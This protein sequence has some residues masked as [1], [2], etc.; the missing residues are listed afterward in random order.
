MPRPPTIRL[1]PLQRRT[2]YGV[3]TLLWLSGALWLAFHYFLR[4]PS[5]FGDKPHALEIWWLRLHGLAGFAA[6]VAV[7]SMLPVHV[8]RAWALD[9]NR[10]SGVVMKM[11]FFW[12]AT[13]A[14]AL[15][16][17]ATESNETWLPLLHWIVGLSLPLVLVIHVRRGRRRD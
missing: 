3:I 4:V 1:S 10:M 12:L 13:S 14:Y 11:V 6:L 16:Y 7:G 5:T 15:Y 8:G 9:K 17:F 2:V